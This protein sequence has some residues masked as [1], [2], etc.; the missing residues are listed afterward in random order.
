MMNAEDGS[1]FTMYGI[2]YDT[3]LSKT[4]ERIYNHLIK[5]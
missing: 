1:T 5:I 4:T 2:D 3:T